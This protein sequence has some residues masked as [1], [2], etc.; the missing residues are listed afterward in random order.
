MVL[1]GKFQLES[2]WL[3]MGGIVLLVTAVFLGSRTKSISV[4]SCSACAP[5]GSEQ[6]AQARQGDT[7]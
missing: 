3:T 5:G 2:E 6:Q 4:A 1:I 7:P